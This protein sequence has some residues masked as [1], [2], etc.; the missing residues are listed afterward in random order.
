MARKTYP[1]ADLTA[2]VNKALATEAEGNTPEFR[3][4]LAGL[5][6]GVLHDTGNYHG[7]QYIGEWQEGVTDET[8][9]VYY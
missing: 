3:S 4:A 8:R 5:L 7:F 1:V 9:R 2:R 6:E